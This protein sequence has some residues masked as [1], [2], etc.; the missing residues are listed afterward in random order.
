MNNT[1]K[2]GLAA[3][4]SLLM[5][6]IT[7][8]VFVLWAF[9]YSR[10]TDLII[11][12]D[13]PFIICFTAIFTAIYFCYRKMKK[14]LPIHGQ[15]Q[16]GKSM[17]QAI[18]QALIIVGTLGIFLFAFDQDSLSRSF[19][20]IFVVIIGVVLT[21]ANFALPSLLLKLS[22]SEDLKRR[23][24]LIGSTQS[25]ETFK[26]W[27]D[28]ERSLSADVS[29]Y[30]SLKS[31]ANDFGDIKCAGNITNLKEAISANKVT[32][33]VLL[34]TIN[35]NSWFRHVTRI[36][37]AHGCRLV[38]KN[39]LE[40]IIGRKLRYFSEAEHQF[41]TLQKEPLEN[42]ANR[43]FKRIFDVAVSLPVVVFILPPLCLYVWLR[44]R[45][46]SPGPLLFKQRRYGRNQ[47]T[48]YIWKFRTMHF[49][50]DD[51]PEAEAKR[52]LQQASKDD[53]RIFPTGAFL[54]KTS[55]DEFPQFVNSLLGQ[56]SVVGPRP[57]PLKLDES[58]STQI[59]S[60]TS[61][62][63]VK[64]GITGLAQCNGFRGETI[65]KELMI[66]RIKHDILYLENWNVF[67][68]IT[69]TIKTIKQVFK[70]LNTSY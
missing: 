45:K 17:V 9:G 18:N 20:L 67:V 21:P 16:W 57:H 3:I 66:Q 68:D 60:Y 4:Q 15:F 19:I 10:A 29:C 69:L 13:V 35:S 64:P 12:S 33:I 53:P 36:A 62:H 39:P 7:C 48:F 2:E 54:R 37:D 70:P 58:Y 42:P 59:E 14:D 61:R 40:N 34:E 38:I 23:Y 8:I 28:Q 50:M 27:I 44:Q 41:F 47:E 46:E 5:G 26:D 22:I 24:L 51:S 56:M 30:L 31:G 6:T 1:R 65:E 63:Y 32:H 25:L 55:L 11:F 52:A 49:D 43:L